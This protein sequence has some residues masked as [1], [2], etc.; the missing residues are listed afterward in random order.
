VLK[1]GSL[2]FDKGH[3]NFRMFGF[4]EMLNLPGVAA[5]CPQ[6]GAFIQYIAFVYLLALYA[7]GISN[8]ARIDVLVLSFGAPVL[9]FLIS[10]QKHQLTGV[11]ATALAFYT[12]M[13]K[14]RLL[15]AP[16][17]I[18]FWAVL[19]FAVGIKY[20]FIISAAAILLLV[21]LKEGWGKHLLR[22]MLTGGGIFL[23]FNAP[24]YVF[25][26]FRFGDPVSPLLE[27]FRP[28]PDPVV[29]SLQ[30]FLHD[31]RESPFPFPANLFLPSS[32]GSFTTI[33]GLPAL[34]LV[35]FLLHR[36][37][38]KEKIAVVAFAM[39]T[40][41]GGQPTARFFLEPLLWVIPLFAATLVATRWQ[42]V[43]FTGLRLQ[44]LVLLPVLLLTAGL[45]LPGLI[46]NQG[47]DTMM[48]RFAIGYSESRWIDASIPRDAKICVGLRSR[49]LIPRE[50][51]PVEYT[52]YYIKQ[53]GDFASFEKLAQQSGA[54]YY[55]VPD[56]AMNNFGTSFNRPPVA[57]ENFTM[58]TR[59]PLNYTSYTLCIYKVNPPA[60]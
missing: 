16:Y 6:F 60:R 12:L 5:G 37:F 34:I 54:D 13:D 24:V 27:R 36:R 23:L 19:T 2:Y 38:T 35:L 59:N 55:V 49:S 26:A 57:C 21:I 31:F 56:Y 48:R 1:T 52:A 11:V 18:L 22:T 3:L 25:K 53:G 20:S 17:A 43:L 9:M 33:I 29:L 14:G 28:G 39:F 10:S 46:T 51:M 42:V 4:G 47:R 15:R 30:Q 58:A 40:V 45:F 50:H 8:K 7:E 44:L 32:P 41:I